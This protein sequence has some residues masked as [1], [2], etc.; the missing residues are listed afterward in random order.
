MKRY[1]KYIALAAT[2]LTAA[3]SQDTILEEDILQDIQ[4]TR[5]EDEDTVLT[6]R[7]YI[8]SYLRQGTEGYQ[9]MFQAIKACGLLDQLAIW[10]DM[11][12]EELYQTHWLDL[13]N[14]YYLGFAEGN[15][16]YAPQ[17][18]N[19]GYTIFAETDDFWYSQGIDPKAA[20]LCS[21][22]T[23]WI[24]ANG[25][26]SDTYATDGNYTS[27]KHLLYQWVTYHILPMRLASDKL[28]NHIN[29][30]GFSLSNPT[31]LGI[32]VYEYYTTMGNRRLFKLY[33]SKESNGVYINRFP[34]LDNGRHGTGHET[35]CDPDK[36]GARIGTDSPMAVTS[37]VVNAC[38]YPIDAPISYTDDVRQNL[39]NERI[40]FDVMSLL[41][42]AMTNDIRLKQSNAERDR[43]ICFPREYD[44]FENLS[45]G[46]DTYMV[47]Y[48]TWNYD[49][50]N[51]QRDEV[52]AVGLYDITIK[53][54]PVPTKGVYELRYKTLGNNNRGMAQVYF[55]T[56]KERMD[57]IGLPLDLTLS[58][59]NAAKTGWEDDTYDDEHDATVDKRL[60]NNGYMKG[61]QSIQ[62]R[63]ATER[64]V[65]NNSNIRHILLQQEL[66]PD[67]TYYVRFK[68]ALDNPMKEFHMDYFELCPQTVIHNRYQPEDI[69]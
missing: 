13:N 65:N 54:P 14:M 44:Y 58:F 23:N 10:R 27:P 18:R 46:R 19:I 53:L 16:A 5:T 40:R 26:Y 43:Y 69:W 57:A 51:L 31:E 12:Y 2:I 33:E 50:C 29:E 4:T 6:A 21:N 38:I 39:G 60:R 61:A 15:T 41:P 35:G 8:E 45:I 63:N 34:Q 32:P 66:D 37:D 67:K 28:V 30:Y 62:A 42:E 7:K 24:K 20:D 11:E 47:Y 49:W 56:D 59:Y 64:S 9:V 22:L 17:H 36:T 48:N 3:C 25:L 68:N 55:G 52:K 1:T